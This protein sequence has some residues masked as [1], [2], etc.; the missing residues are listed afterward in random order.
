MAETVKKINK[1]KNPE[2]YFQINIIKGFKYVDRAG[3]IVN[4]YHGKNDEVPIFT[5]DL[6]GLL[7]NNPIDKIEQLKI[8]SEVI[9]AKFSIVDSLD[10]I[11]QKF[12]KE[13]KKILDILEVNKIRRIG[14]RNLFVYEF[15]NHDKQEQYLG[16]LLTTKD[17]KPSIIGI[18]VKTGRDFKANLIIQPVVK[19][20]ASKTQAIMFDIDIFKTDNL[21][22]EK[23]SDTLKKFRE[24]LNDTNGFLKIVNETFDK[25]VERTN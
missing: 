15:N 5:M 2:S 3:E 20:D 9:W 24:Y 17:L 10:F 4:I 11:S 12:F 7:V 18:E 16:N 23:I 22:A 14:W 19:N 8:S 13:A 6:A 1:L 25:N 21:D